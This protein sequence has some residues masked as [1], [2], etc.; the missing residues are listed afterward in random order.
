MNCSGKHAA[1]LLACVVNGWDTAT[2]L[3]A[4]HPLQER[5]RD[6]LQ[7]FAGERI[8]ATGVDGCGAPV[9]AVSVTGLA[10][11]IAKISTSSV[12]SPF[13][14]FRRAAALSAA[15][16]ENGWVIDGP[17]RANTVVI[18]QLGL[19]AKLGAEGVMVMSTPEGTT[20]A[21]KVLDGNL[22]VA[23]IVALE[24]LAS[25]G[26]VG[27]DQI[28]RLRPDLELEVLGGGLRVGAIRVSAAVTTP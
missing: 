11:G 21:L 1:M 24:L 27:R 5:I 17:G 6:V 22:R 12:S 7:R 4:D 3:H 9:Y 13:E 23:T 8:A 14:I 18:E 28:E 16:R 2:Y 20:A 15:I 25:V 26:A 10:R 19:V